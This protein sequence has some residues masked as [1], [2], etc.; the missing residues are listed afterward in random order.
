VTVV[1]RAQ[2]RM[3]ARQGS[4]AKRSAGV[5]GGGMEETGIIDLGQASRSIY[6]GATIFSLQIARS[7][8]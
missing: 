1:P 2:R 3:K 8:E 4:L 7:P 6:D 5:P